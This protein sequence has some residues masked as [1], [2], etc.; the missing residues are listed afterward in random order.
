MIQV[1]ENIFCEG[2][3]NIIREIAIPLAEGVKSVADEYPV[4][5]EYDF[6]LDARPKAHGITEIAG[7]VGV[8]TFV[9]SWVA[10]TVLNEVYAA[11][12]SPL[13][14]DN[15]SKYFSGKKSNRKYALTITAIDQETKACLVIACV[16]KNL[17]EIESSERHLESVL[18]Y[19]RSA[20]LNS[21]PKEV[22]LVVLE[23]GKLDLDIKV[24]QNYEKAIMGLK[25]MYPAKLPSSYAKNS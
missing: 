22:M 17:E 19:V 3:A 15:L 20:N 6:G 18:S 16:G 1:S 9:A 7:I 5:E 14:K 11:K 10:T 4:T 24:F 8:T 2:D 21:H 23:S 12:L 13:I 25:D